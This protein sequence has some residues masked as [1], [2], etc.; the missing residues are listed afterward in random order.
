MLEFENEQ[1]PY[2]ERRDAIRDWKKYA[3]VFCEENDQIITYAETLF[4]KGVKVKDA[5]HIACAMEAKCDYF[6]STDKKLL[7]ATFDK[8]KVINPIDFIKIL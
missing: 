3:H 7:R 1:N 8:I 6:L 5:L 4:N 2:E